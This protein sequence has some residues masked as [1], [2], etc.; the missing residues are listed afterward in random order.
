MA[1]MA[2]R[3]RAMWSGFMYWRPP[4]V[5]KPRSW[6]RRTSDPS[7]MEVPTAVSLRVVRVMYAL[8]AR[9]WLGGRP[10]RAATLSVTTMANGGGDAGGLEHG[11]GLDRLGSVQVLEDEASGVAQLVLKAH[12][13]DGEKLLRVEGAELADERVDGLHLTAGEPR[14]VDGDVG[15]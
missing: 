8:K 5:P 3:T 4:T 1:R 15:R 12:L 6:K 7:G 10:R 14:N 9:L 2:L 13:G 11:D